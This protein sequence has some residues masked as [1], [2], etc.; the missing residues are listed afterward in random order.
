MPEAVFEYNVGRCDPNI[1]EK[2]YSY[3]TY[4]GE[5][6]TGH[7]AYQEWHRLNHIHIVNLT[8]ATILWWRNVQ[9]TKHFHF[10]HLT[11]YCILSKIMF[12][13]TTTVEFLQRCFYLRGI[14][15]FTWASCANKYIV[16]HEMDCDLRNALF[17]F[18]CLGTAIAGL[19]W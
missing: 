9:G 18:G 13:V 2:K 10:F 6:P 1:I 15:L 14:S 5:K 12:L 17:P 3:P 16:Y 7:L 11:L 8:N 4:T 19:L